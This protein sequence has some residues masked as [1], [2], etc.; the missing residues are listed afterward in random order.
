MKQWKIPVT[1][2]VC[3]MLTVEAD[4]LSEAMDIARDDNCEIPCPTDNDYVDGSWRLSDDDIDL[5][6]G[7]YNDGQEDEQD[8]TEEPE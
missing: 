7:C 2:E 5:I 3:A 4:S 6:R 1:W 8:M